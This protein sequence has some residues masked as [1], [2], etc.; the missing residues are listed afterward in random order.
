MHIKSRE[1]KLKHDDSTAQA[2]Y[3]GGPSPVEKRIDVLCAR[4]EMGSSG[5]IWEK[6]RPLDATHAS[7]SRG[8]KNFSSGWKAFFN[9]SSKSSRPNLYLQLSRKAT[10]NH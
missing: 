9:Y 7:L 4:V 1:K 2:I 6:W 5:V 10:H 8:D 3:V